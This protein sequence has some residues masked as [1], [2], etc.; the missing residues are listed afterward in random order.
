METRS[1]RAL[2]LK[3]PPVLLVILAAA[4]MSIT[5]VYAPRVNFQ[6]PFQSTVAWGFGALGIAI[7]ALGVLQFKL[8][9]TTV[10]PTKPQS[11]SAL[12]RTGIYK[13]TRNPMYLGFVLVLVGWAAGSPNIIGFLILPVFVLFMNRFQIKPE[14]RVLTSIFGKDFKEYCSETRRW[15]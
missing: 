11:S 15:I 12:V 4:L 7:S 3:M 13:H 5:A 8:A 1:L 2:E 14:E 9:R 10:N 6:F